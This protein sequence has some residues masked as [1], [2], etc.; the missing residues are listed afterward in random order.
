MEKAYQ[1]LIQSQ[2]NDLHEVFEE[3][4]A[5]IRGQEED[6]LLEGDHEDDETSVPPYDS[7]DDRS[8]ESNKSDELKVAVFENE[9]EEGHG[10]Y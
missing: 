4:A 1:E 10:D 6:A 2:E 7:V 3:E 8:D 9:G 5:V